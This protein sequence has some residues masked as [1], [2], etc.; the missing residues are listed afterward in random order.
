MPIL[1]P[2]TYAHTERRELLFTV[3]RKSGQISVTRRMSDTLLESKA[4]KSYRLLVYEPDEQ[5][6]AKPWKFDPPQGPWVAVAFSTW[7]ESGVNIAAYE[8][9]DSQSG[10]T[11]VK[12]RGCSRW[13]QEYF[14]RQFGT[15][16]SAKSA[17]YALKPDL[18]F[19]QDGLTFYV[20]Q[21]KQKPPRRQRAAR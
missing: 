4:G 16:A 2:K 18:C 21:P 19:E 12:Y 17:V 8:F 3:A 20:V 15:D 11:T 14:C 6:K 9:H 13:L 7:N 5:D 1:T 10:R